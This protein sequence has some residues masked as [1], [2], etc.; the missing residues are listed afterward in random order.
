MVFSII[1]MAEI[2]KKAIG[3][4]DIHQQNLTFITFLLKKK[5]QYLKLLI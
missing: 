2:R 1:S 5:K 3:F 4:L